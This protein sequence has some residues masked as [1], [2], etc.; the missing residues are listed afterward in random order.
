MTIKVL[1]ELIDDQEDRETDP[2]EAH[3][4]VEFGHEIDV[5]DLLD[6]IIN[7]ILWVR[8]ISSNRSYDAL[9][10]I[11][12]Q[13]VGDVTRYAFPGRGVRGVLIV[14]W[15]NWDVR[16]N[17]DVGVDRDVRINRRRWVRYRNGWIN[18]SYYSC[19]SVRG[20]E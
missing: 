16:V 12:G 7:L 9:E 15:I 19:R 11:L 17:R 14:T 4:F 5:L 3:P 8:D 18:A 2:E 6:R 10:A 1:P 13:C 20:L